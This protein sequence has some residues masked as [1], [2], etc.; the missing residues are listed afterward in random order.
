MISR[1]TKLFALSGAALAVVAFSLPAVARIAGNRLAS[2][3]IAG[4]R[5]ASNTL[6]VKSSFDAQAVQVSRVTLPDGTVLTA[7]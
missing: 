4:N 6:T 7:R 5:L 2:N 1:R 3:R